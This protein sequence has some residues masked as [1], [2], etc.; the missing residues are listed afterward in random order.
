MV[1]DLARLEPG[2]VGDDCDFSNLSQ[3]FH[4]FDCEFDG[5]MA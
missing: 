3:H 1:M 5:A 4:I 2:W